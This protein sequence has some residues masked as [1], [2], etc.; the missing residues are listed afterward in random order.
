[1]G[2]SGNPAKRAAQ[3]GGTPSHRRTRRDLIDVEVDEPRELVVLNVGGERTGMTVATVDALILS[4][5]NARNHLS[6]DNS[7]HSRACGIQPHEH[8]AACSKDCPTCGG[9]ALTVIV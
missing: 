4:L 2:R 1:M 5:T 3:A 9:N 6:R 7:P 8:G